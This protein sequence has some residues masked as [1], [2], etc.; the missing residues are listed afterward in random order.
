MAKNK[1]GHYMAITRII[2]LLLMT[3]A[4]SLLVAQPVPVVAQADA[5]QVVFSATAEPGSIFGGTGSDK[6]YGFWIWCEASGTSPY[7][8]VCNGSMYFYA[9]AIFTEH[10]TGAVTLNGELATM[11]VS[12]SATAPEYIN[13]TLSNIPPVTAGPTNSVMVTCTTPSGKLGPNGSATATDVIVAVANIV[14]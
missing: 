6:H 10:V 13:C 12:S 8:G 9:F 4:A 7:S 5:T 3:A 1:G 11:R 2:G 14:H